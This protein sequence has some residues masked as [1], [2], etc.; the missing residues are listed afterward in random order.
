M[1]VVRG[2]DPLPR[3]LQRPKGLVVFFCFVFLF[4]VKSELS[5]GIELFR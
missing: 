4:L 2:M 3:F 5:G 1:K